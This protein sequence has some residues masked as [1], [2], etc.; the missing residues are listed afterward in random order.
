MLNRLLYIILK[1]DFIRKIATKFL[2][3][4]TE[5]ELLLEMNNFYNNILRK[6]EKKNVVSMVEKLREE[7]YSI[8]LLSGTYFFIAKVIAERIKAKAYYGTDL[9]IINSIYTGNIKNDLLLS[10]KN[11]VKEYFYELENRFFILITDNKT[12]NTLIKYMNKNYIVINKKNNKFWK[13]YIKKMK[14]AER[15]DFIE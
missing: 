10:K 8:I 15:I 11:I 1:K 3:N 7:G 9:E 12:D 6:K 2:K 5:K 14:L 13:Q 4:K